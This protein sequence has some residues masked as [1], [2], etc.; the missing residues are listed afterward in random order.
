MVELS[1]VLPPF[2]MTPVVNPCLV[3]A[4]RASGTC[5]RCSSP[6][7][8]PRSP[9]P[10]WR[11]RCFRRLASCLTPLFAS[12][13]RR[14]DSMV[15]QYPEQLE[16]EIVPRLLNSHERPTL[17]SSLIVIVRRF[18]A[19]LADLLFAHCVLSILVHLASIAGRL[20][21]AQHNSGK[22]WGIAQLAMLHA[23]RRCCDAIVAQAALRARRQRHV[24]VT[25]VQFWPGRSDLGLLS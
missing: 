14:C 21:V 16:Q 25:D 17:V 19:L 22:G 4:A 6:G 18:F 7:S 9:F 3:G 2:M 1:L 5:S 20:W 8:W 15:S 23:H 10:H 13:R 11:F 12:V 24:P